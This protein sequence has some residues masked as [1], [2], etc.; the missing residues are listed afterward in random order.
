M[1]PNASGSAALPQALRPECTLFFGK[2]RGLVRAGS[3]TTYGPL[4]A[5][6]DREAS[7]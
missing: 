7:T 1:V 4:S 5:S 6:H 3:E 2:A